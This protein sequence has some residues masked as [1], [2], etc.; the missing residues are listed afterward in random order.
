MPLD[1]KVDFVAVDEIQMCGDKER[2]H[3]FTDRLLNFRGQKMTI[4]LGSQVMK[5]IISQLI[6]EVE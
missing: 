5:N 6:N 2:G 1:K 3:I 4:F